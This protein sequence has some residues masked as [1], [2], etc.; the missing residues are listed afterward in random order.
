MGCLRT[1]PAGVV[2]LYSIG[3]KSTLVNRILGRT[4]QWAGAGH[5]QDT[6]QTTGLQGSGGAVPFAKPVFKAFSTSPAGSALLQYHP[7]P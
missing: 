3:K 7:C 6:L 2:M 5:E 1:C 4:G